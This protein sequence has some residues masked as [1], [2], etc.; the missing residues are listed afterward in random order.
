MFVCGVNLE[1]YDS[2]MK[3]ISNASCTTNCLAPLAKVIN[4]TFGIVEGILSRISLMCIRIDDDCP[5]CYRNAKDRRWPKWKRLESWT[6]C[7]SG[8]SLPKTHPYRTLSQPVPEPQR[9]SE[10]SFQSLTANSPEW[11]SV[12][13]LPMSLLSI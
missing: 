6:W 8:I 9:Q 5:C 4:D 13:V 12:S 1:K 7:Q 11:P 3:I 2:S 10:K